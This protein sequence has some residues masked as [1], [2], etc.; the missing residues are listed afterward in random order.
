MLDKMLKNCEC[1]PLSYIIYGHCR[2]RA[3]ELA[4]QPDDLFVQTIEKVKWA[5]AG[6]ETEKNECI[7]LFMVDN[8]SISQ[9]EFNSGL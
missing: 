4:L 3:V 9:K 5:S 6:Y 7:P 2:F 8:I 1:T